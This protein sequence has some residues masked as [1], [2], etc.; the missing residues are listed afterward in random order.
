MKLDPGTQQTDRSTT[1]LGVTVRQIKAHTGRGLGK[2]EK[3]KQ[4]EKRIG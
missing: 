4:G 1:E 3:K 2:E